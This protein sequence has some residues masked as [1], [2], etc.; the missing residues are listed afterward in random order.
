M[1][2]AEIP[3][4]NNQFPKMEKGGGGRSSQTF[5]NLS[6]KFCVILFEDLILGELKGQGQCMTDKG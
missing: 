3:T 6:Y 4:R 5:H 2:S 1:T